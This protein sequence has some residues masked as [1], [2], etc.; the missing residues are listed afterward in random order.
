MEQLMELAEL[1]LQTPL[2]WWFFLGAVV[3]SALARSGAFRTKIWNAIFIGAIG[4]SVAGAYVSLAGYNW[5]AAGMIAAIATILGY[6]YKEIWRWRRLGA[7]MLLIVFRERLVGAW[8]WNWSTY[9]SWVL[10]L[11][12]LTI[13]VWIMYPL[14]RDAFKKVP[15]ES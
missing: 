2:H 9:S 7:L 4:T 1:T 12:F 10:T 11:S 15:Q 13:L 5:Q 14:F 6:I 8:Q 3:I